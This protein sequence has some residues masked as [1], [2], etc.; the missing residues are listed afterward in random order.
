MWQLWQLWQLWQSMA[1]RRLPSRQ[2]RTGLCA[3]ED[4]L[5]LRTLSSSI[6]E[7]LRMRLISSPH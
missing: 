2:L 3:S 4:Q 1:A 5:W 7:A 6:C